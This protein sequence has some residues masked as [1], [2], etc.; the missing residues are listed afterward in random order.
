MKLSIISPTFNEAENVP[1]LVAEISRS[2]NGID[3]EIL[4]VDDNSPDQ[5]WAKAEELSL[6]DS[7]VRVLRRMRNPGLGRAVIDGFRA[8]EGDAVACIDADLQHDPSILPKM[9]EELAG[10]SDVVVGSR[11]VEGGGTGNW[12]W[13]RRLESWIATKLAQVFLGVRLKDPMSGYFLMW[14]K[15][16]STV[17]QELTAEGFKI[18]LEILA[19][20]QPN[21]VREVPYT[22]RT[23]TAGESKLSNTV[24][25]QYLAQ[26]WRLSW[27]G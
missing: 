6:Q 15:D 17:Q 5:T 11:Y 20:L 23:R 21:N 10:G 14:R 16:F 19:K 12:N 24:V 9:L 18:L 25:F 13:L 1:R 22:F 2:L 7:K 4:I 27:L 3:Y 26:L 8:A